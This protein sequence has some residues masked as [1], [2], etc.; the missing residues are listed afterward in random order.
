MSLFT[1]KAVQLGGSIGSTEG[2]LLLEKFGRM[3]DWFFLRAY[4]PARQRRLKPQICW[5][6]IKMI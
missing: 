1:S 5:D 4:P 6:S 2:G 3:F